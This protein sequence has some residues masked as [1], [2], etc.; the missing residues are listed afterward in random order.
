[1]ELNNIFIWRAASVEFQLNLHFYA[2]RLIYVVQF[3]SVITN[4]QLF[5]QLF[6]SKS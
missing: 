3:S 6:E 1:M 5:L 4:L 2:L